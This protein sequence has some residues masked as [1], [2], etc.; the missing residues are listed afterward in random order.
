M[1]GKKD[2]LRV[3]ANVEV[4]AASLQAIVANAKKISGPDEKGGYR[5]DTADKTSEMISRFLLENDF[6]SF[7][8][9]IENYRR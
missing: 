3:R 2:T 9:N 1:P 8:K 5:I 4:T 7:V 6:E